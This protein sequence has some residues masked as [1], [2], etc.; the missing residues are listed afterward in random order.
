MRACV[1]ACVRAC[2]RACVRAYMI[3][4][5]CASVVYEQGGGG[6]CM[7]TCL[8]VGVGVYVYVFARAIVRDL[9]QACVHPMRT[10]LCS[11][12]CLCGRTCV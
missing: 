5:T 2:A 7:C 3:V 10:R 1:R 9:V 8:R 12:L 4:C 6:G 11:R